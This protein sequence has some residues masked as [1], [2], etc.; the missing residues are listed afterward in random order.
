MCLLCRQL[1]TERHQRRSLR[2][3]SKSYRLA[4]CKVIQ[5]SGGF[6]IPRCGLRSRISDSFSGE[7]GFWVPIVSGIPES[8]SCNSGFH[9][10]GFSFHNSPFPVYRAWND[11]DNKLSN[12]SL[13]T[14]L[15]SLALPE[16]GCDLPPSPPEN[17]A[18]TCY[19][20]GGSSFC[21]LSCN[22][23]KKLFK[24]VYY[25]HCAKGPSPKWSE[26]PDCVGK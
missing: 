20:Y 18:L 4:S 9:I 22:E 15:F 16:L 1:I 6:W 2:R 11:T 21:T 17:G 26:I 8:L 7:L 12:A 23:D 3:T 10:L 13:K 14:I 24:K 5:D 19:N 25:I